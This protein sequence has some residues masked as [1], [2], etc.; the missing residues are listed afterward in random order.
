[1][2]KPINPAE[3][4]EDFDDRELIEAEFQSMVEGLALD[5][6]APTTYLDELARF[7]VENRFAPTAIPRK[8]FKSSVKDIFSAFTR[9]KNDPKKF[10][11]APNDGAV[12]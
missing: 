4:P 9:W 8:S 12:L 5:E 3:Q 11:D 1:M 2:S 6:S 7:E 10:P